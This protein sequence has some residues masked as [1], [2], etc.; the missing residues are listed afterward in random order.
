MISAQGLGRG[1]RSCDA[2]WQKQ[3]FWTS[4]SFSCG[5]CWPDIIAATRYDTLFGSSWPGVPQLSTNVSCLLGGLGGAWVISCGYQWYR[6]RRWRKFQNR[7]PIGEVGC[8]ESRMAERIHWWTQT[9]L[10]LF[11]LEW[12]QWLQW[13]THNCWMSLDVVWCSAAVVVV[14]A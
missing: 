14:V 1:I 7:N 11:F 2:C 12:L 3:S 4:T 6:T 13:L 10:E 8:C 5:R 9:W